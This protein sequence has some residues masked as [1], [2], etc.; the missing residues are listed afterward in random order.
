MKNSSTLPM[1][2]AFNTLL[3]L[4][5]TVKVLRSLPTRLHWKLLFR[6][7]YVLDTLH[8]CHRWCLLQ[9]TQTKTK[10]K[11]AHT[12]T[13]VYFLIYTTSYFK[14]VVVVVAKRTMTD[15]SKHN[16]NI[17]TLIKQAQ[18]LYVKMFTYCTVKVNQLTV[19]RNYK[20]TRMSV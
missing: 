3:Y 17:N 9:S 15:T 8:G 16:N 11:K 5:Y 2:N 1:N 18:Q 14:I 6:M 19:N 12:H 10:D 20:R 4:T 13:C 7:Q